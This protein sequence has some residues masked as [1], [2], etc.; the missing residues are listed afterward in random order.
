MN[1]LRLGD[2]RGAEPGFGDHRDVCSSKRTKRAGPC[3]I[4]GAT[5]DDCKREATVEGGTV[6]ERNREATV[7]VEVTVAGKTT[8]DDC[9]HEATV[10]GATID[11]SKCEATVEG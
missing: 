8:V 7:E 2:V 1:G 5:V 11:D 4:E 9:R 6:D 3:A 10:E